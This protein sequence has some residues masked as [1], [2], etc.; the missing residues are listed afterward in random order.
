MTFTFTVK[1]ADWVG[2][3]PIVVLVIMALILMLVDLI[4]PHA[5]ERSKH[6]GP[7]NFTILPMISLIGI[8]GAIVATIVLLI[9]GANAQVFNHMVAADAGTLSAHLLILVAGA[10][11][12]LLSPAYLKR[13]DL[14]H[15]GEY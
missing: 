1:P 11:G 6:S 14:V 15:Q 7:A 12:V 5:G 10:L 4:L 9:W 2:I 13:L 3:T 8:L